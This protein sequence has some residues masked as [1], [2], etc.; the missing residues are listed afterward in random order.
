MA[1]DQSETTQLGKDISRGASGIAKDEDPIRA[2]AD[3]QGRIAIAAA[4]TV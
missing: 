3:V 4:L 1:I 2:V